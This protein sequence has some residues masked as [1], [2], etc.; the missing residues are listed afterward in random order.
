[1]KSR[2]FNMMWPSQNFHLCSWTIQHSFS[3]KNWKI[4]I[5]P[6]FSSCDTCTRYKCYWVLIFLHIQCVVHLSMSKQE[7]PALFPQHWDV[8]YLEKFRLFKIRRQN[9]QSPAIVKTSQQFFNI[10]SIPSYEN[11]TESGP[12]ERLYEKTT[13]QNAED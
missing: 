5:D 12:A 7:N 1:M 8:H 10:E 6:P 2:E 3:K 11:L 4:S 9:C 13:S